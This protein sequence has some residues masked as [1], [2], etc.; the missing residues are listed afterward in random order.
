MKKKIMLGVNELIDEIKSSEVFRSN[1]VGFFVKNNE[2]HLRLLI[3]D[4]YWETEK[5]KIIFEYLKSQDDYISR[6]LTA[7]YGNSGVSTR[8]CDLAKDLSGNSYHFLKQTREVFSELFKNDLIALNFNLDML[9]NVKTYLL[10]QH[11]IKKVDTVKIDY[12]NKIL[13]NFCS[14]KNYPD[15]FWWLFL[16]A[17][18]Q[19][20]ITL[21]FDKIPANQYIKVYELLKEKCY[22]A[23]IFN[24]TQLL[25]I[26]ENDFWDIRKYLVAT[27]ENHL[28]LSGPSLME[29]FDQYKSKNI[30][31]ELSDSLKSRKL[32]KVSIIITDPIL[33][34]VRANCGYPIRDVSGTVSTLEEIFYDLF[35][36][37]KIQLHIYFIPL[38]QIDHAVI[39]EEFMAFRSTKLWTSDRKYKG[40]FCLYLATQYVNGSSEYKAH[41]DYL[42]TIMDNCTKIYPAEDLDED[43]LSQNT[44]RGKHMHW[45][46]KLYD[47][48]YKYIECYKLYEK[49]LFNFVCD[50]WT[51]QQTIIGEFEPSSKILN[52]K[53]LFDYH[54][55][56]DFQGDKTQKILLPY[57]QT[58][59]KLF[60][61][62]IRKHDRSDHSYCRIFP[63]LDLG[64]PNNAQRLA[65][66]FATGMLIT[67]NCGIDIVPI[68]ATVNVCTSSIFKLSNFNPDCLNSPKEYEKKLTKLFAD[69]SEEKGYSFSFT[70]GNH[71]F[72][73]AKNMANNKNEYYLVLHSSANELKNS[74]MGLY[75]VEKNWYSDK[76]KTQAGENGRYF[77]YLKD[78]DA[79][80]FI[81]MAHHFEH[82]NIQ[83]HTCLAKYINNNQSFDENEKWINHHYYMPTDSSIAI[84]TFAEKIGVQVPLF[85]APGKPIYIFEIG[86]DNWQVE[87]G[88]DKGKVCLVP[89]G[90][91]QKIEGINN[92]QIKNNN[93]V[94]SIENNKIECPISSKS[95]IECNEK[96]LRQFKNGEQFLRVG[97]RMIQGNIKLRLEPIYEYSGNTI[98]R[99]HKHE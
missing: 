61:E 97:S 38:L 74:Y 52:Y 65:G 88:G 86:E 73:I 60:D 27:A 67:W 84:G 6:L 20:N 64:F 76:F 89:H 59:N 37:L 7:N 23:K 14:R 47:K 83:I 18:F 49:Q 93:L 28:I 98:E 35:E 71:F 30:V 22:P 94:L 19:T 11:F 3:P 51:P 26:N 46:K 21:F 43:A 9:P 40:A 82:Y 42:S 72:I 16:Y 45:R 75:P 2:N 81:T 63:S 4:K 44:A 69:I 17:L 95:H 24:Q 1:N 36:N 99:K 91:G 31:N 68:D 77:R 41:K 80:H 55:L 56:L 13:I 79:R 34:D 39:T 15:F 85:S 10:Q 57:I 53:D 66:G 8:C 92:I 12:F 87:L 90:W 58:T 29:A 54:N 70:S 25:E 62:A 96:M 32:T 48:N 78:E 5:G 50:T 33:F